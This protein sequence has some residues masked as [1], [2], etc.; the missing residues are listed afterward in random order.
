MQHNFAS[1]LK[2]AAST[3]LI[4]RG[5]VQVIGLSGLKSEIGARWDKLKESTWAHLET[6]LRQKL[7]A[8]DFY[9]QIDDTAFLVTMPS[10]TVDEAQIF[11]LRIA[12]ELYSSLLGRCET[13]KLEIARATKVEDD[14][15]YTA[16]VVGDHLRL[17][18]LQAGL[19]KPSSEEIAMLKSIQGAGKTAPQ[20]KF[21]HKFIPL[22]D[23]QKEAITTSYCVSTVDQGA[24]EG[25]GVAGRVRFEIALTV[26]RLRRATSV[27]AAHFASGDRFLVAIPVTYDVLSSP[28]GRMEVFTVCRSLAA[29]LRPYLI[30]E[31][32]ELPLGVP[33][34]RLTELVASLKPFCRAVTTQLPARIPNCGAYL[35]AGLHAIGLSLREVETGGGE[36]SSEIFKLCVAAKRQRVRSYALDVPNLE[37]L[38][39]AYAQ[40][41]NL[42]SSPLIGV[43]QDLPAPLRRLSASDLLK[44]PKAA[45]SVAA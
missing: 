26:S 7:S 20:S 9:T 38:R 25:L 13:G 45:H 18:A 35:G 39:S 33:Q 10:T 8:T 15:L 24:A 21:S 11:C 19:D 16:P 6:L 31:I 34:S 22:W 1:E 29:E 40:G 32:S 42:M 43:A 23:A 27:L 41:I 30:F 37:L 28:V 44:E 4:E 5:C 2:V 36:M 3:T 17:L 14:L 12:H